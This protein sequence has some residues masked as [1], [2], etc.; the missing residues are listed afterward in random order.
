M[1]FKVLLIGQNGQ[2]STYLQRSFAAE[3]DFELTVAGR[4]SI[5]LSKPETIAAA[6]A[7]FS[8][9]LIVNPAAYTAVDQA[10]SEPEQAFKINAEAVA[11]IAQYCAEHDC[12]LIHYSTDY[13]FAGIAEAAY[14]E[15]DP[16]GPNGVYGASKLAGEQAIL[17]SDAPAIILRT[18]WVY[19]NHGKNFYKTMLA[20]SDSRSELNIVAD[21][22]G[23]PTYAGSIAQASKQLIKLI[24]NQG[25]I[26]SEQKGIYHF[27][28]QGQ[29]SWC[30]FA[31]AIFVENQINHMKVSPIDTVDYPTPAQRPSYSVLNNKKLEQTFGIILPHWGTALA[32]CA[33]ETSQA[34]D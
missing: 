1:S 19:S 24:S 27:T 25:T 8:P 28:C 13:V 29:T 23:A 34:D 5:D 33:A 4:D 2:V 21:Q 16:V 14:S 17:E 6:L 22:I 10:E 7:S 15:S 12:P 32:Q 30:D 11:V 26:T 31:K 18:A 9:Q 20:L 3:V